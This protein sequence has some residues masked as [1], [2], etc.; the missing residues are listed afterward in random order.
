MVEGRLFYD[1]S[2]YTMRNEHICA[3]VCIIIQEA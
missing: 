3:Q 1:Q 2:S